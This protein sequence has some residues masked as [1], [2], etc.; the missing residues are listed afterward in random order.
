MS[1]NRLLRW[2]ILAALI[3]SVLALPVQSAFA[4]SLAQALNAP[5]GSNVL[6]NPGFEGGMRRTSLSSW[7]SDGWNPWFIHTADQS[8]QTFGREPEFAVAERPSQA[9]SGNKFMR[10]FSTFGHHNGGLWQRVPAPRGATATFSLWM[11]GWSSRGDTFG[12]SE[13]GVYQKWVGID[14]YGGT[15]ATSANVVWSPANTDMDRYVEMTVSTTVLGD[16]VTVFARGEPL[17]PVKHNDVL[18]DD[19]SLVF[20]S[21]GP[22]PVPPA[23]PAPTPAPSPAPAIVPGLEGDSLTFQGT[24][25]VASG[26][27]LEWYLN[28]GGANTMGLPLSNAMKD[29]IT[30]GYSQYFQN[31]VLDWRTDPDGSSVVERRLLGDLLNPEND[32]PLAESQAPAEEYLFFPYNDTP[33]LG[34]F[35]ADYA[36][37]GQPVHFLEVFQAYGGAGT[38]G[39][40]KEEPKQSNGVWTQRFQAATF[41]YHPE[42]DRDGFVPG[43]EVPYRD[44]IVSLQPLGRVY[45]TA[46]KI[47]LK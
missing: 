37:G 33:G 9:H 36:A 28:H 38:F 45:V 18:V 22:A 8:Q 12:V 13:G 34:H 20:G 3:A 19:A 6:A 10:W 30:G 7:V 21:Q 44:L 27:W 17:W 5:S 1:V 15:D 39:L 11:Y 35:V 24:G 2:C 32:P 40:P 41:E 29:P 43:T 23:P 14:P 25:F 42:Y 46:N 4:E 16:A 47:V 26:M 31:A